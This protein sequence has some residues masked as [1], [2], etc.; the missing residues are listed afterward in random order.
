MSRT[1]AWILI[2]TG[3]IGVA[4]AT[5]GADS[6][7]TGTKPAEAAPARTSARDPEHGCPMLPSTTLIERETKRKATRLIRRCGLAPGHEVR[8]WMTVDTAGRIADAG[9]T[10]ADTPVVI[11]CV[12]AELRAWQ[13]SR[14]AAAPLRDQWWPMRFDLVFV[15]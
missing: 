9:V 14:Q 10:S 3:A 4:T 6:A 1:A 12:T 15:P 13:F 5:A 2:G 8:A 7:S 11:S